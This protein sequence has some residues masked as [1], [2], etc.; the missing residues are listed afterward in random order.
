MAQIATPDLQK[1]L[2]ALRAVRDPSIN[3][4]GMAGYIHVLQ[5]EGCL[6]KR[7]TGLIP[8]CRTGGAAAS[9]AWVWGGSFIG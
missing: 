6:L 4:Q 5:D 1:I 2:E 7:D 8:M 3:A 9:L